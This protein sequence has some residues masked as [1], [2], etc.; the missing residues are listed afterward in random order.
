MIFYIIG[1]IF[2]AWLVLS[3][4]YSTWYHLQNYFSAK[5]NETVVAHDLDSRGEIKEMNRKEFLN[6]VL[7]KQIY[8]IVVIIIVLYF[9]IF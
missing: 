7:L 6:K 8:K 5:E 1:W 3:T 2:V 4:I 9:L